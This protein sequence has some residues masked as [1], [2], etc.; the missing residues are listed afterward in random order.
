MPD[1]MGLLYADMSV[2]TL[3]EGR[4]FDGF[5]PGEFTDMWGN[6]VEVKPD[7]LAIYV[8]NTLAAIEATRAESGELVG[9]P[10]DAEYHDRGRAAGWIVDVMLKD[11]VLRFKPRWTEIGQELISKG[12]MRFFSSTFDPSKKVIRG[13]SLTNWPAT[14]DKQQR[15]LLRPIELTTGLFSVEKPPDSVG[16]GGLATLGEAIG[17]AIANVMNLS[18]GKPD[19]MRAN[20]KGVTSMTVELKDLTAEQRAELAGQALVQA[21]EA[22]GAGT[23]EMAGRVADLVE[24]RATEKAAALVARAE[25]ERG[26]RQLAA[27]LA[28]GSKDKPVGLP[29]E[30]DELATFLLDLSDEQ[31]AKAE[32]LFRHIRESGLVDFGEA[33][34]GKQQA[35]GRELPPAIARKLDAGALTL[36]DL[37][38]PILALGD[39]TEY[40]LTKWNK[41]N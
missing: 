28:G 39:L 33:G 4:W 3:M 27:D 17:Q 23:A 40:D 21:L 12:I 18:G 38:D 11:G 35:G 8:E 2:D 29:V 15:V 5:A 6:Y 32:A 26:V 24:E 30:A 10:I 14:V 20:N 34:H 16:A 37:S 31:R 36:A 7:E 19:L 25:T 1:L 22:P 9:L 13:G 41:E